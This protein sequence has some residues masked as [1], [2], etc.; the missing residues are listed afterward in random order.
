MISIPLF[1]SEGHA[2]SYL[3]NQTASSAFVHPSFKLD[4][5]IYSQLIAKGFRRSGDFVYAPHCTN[6][7]ECKATRIPVER[8]QPNRSQ[9]RCQAKNIKT[10]TF[11]KPARFE[12]SHYELYIRYQN[13]RHI[14]GNMAQSSP[15]EYMD[16]LSSTWCHTK[17][18]EFHTDGQLCAVTVVDQLDNALSA[19]YTFFDPGYSAIS[20]GV[21]AV[22][23]QIEWA[24]KLNLKWVYLGFWIKEC[25]K[26]SYKINYH[27][28]ELLINNQWSES[29]PK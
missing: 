16:F 19:V 6:C 22:L 7:S 29:I 1:Q 25:P 28:V 26:M 8:F 13:S 10:Q 9:Q 17:F 20:P 21:F 15:S 3:E 23:W 5:T 18:V 11:I 2:C 14:G 24:K 27:P 12:Q 4:T